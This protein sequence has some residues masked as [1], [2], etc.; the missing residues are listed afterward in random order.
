MDELEHVE[1]HAGDVE[2][3]EEPNNDDQDERQ[4]Y[5]TL[6]LLLSVKQIYLE[7]DTT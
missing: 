5:V 7:N 4:V 2:E 1:E 3:E 6:H